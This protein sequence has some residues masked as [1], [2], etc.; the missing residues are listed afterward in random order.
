MFLCGGFNKVPSS[1]STETWVISA[2]GATKTSQGT[3]SVARGG[4]RLVTLQDG[5]ILIIGGST[6]GYD[7]ASASC[8]LYDPSDGTV[9]PVGSMAT[10]R[11]GHGVWLLSNGDVLVAGGSAPYFT[12]CLASA[13]IYNHVS[14]TWSATGSLNQ[15][16]SDFFYAVG[17]NGNPVAIAGSLNTNGGFTNT[18]EQYSSGTW[19]LKTSVVPSG[20]GVSQEDNLAIRLENGDIFWSGGLVA[21]LAS[22]GGTGTKHS[23]TYTASTDTLTARADQNISRVMPFTFR[24]YDGKILL[25]G[26]FDG[27]DTGTVYSSSELYDPE[28]DTW[29][30]VGSLSLETCGGYYDPVLITSPDANPLTVGGLTTG[31]FTNSDVMELFTQGSVPV[32]TG[33]TLVQ[34]ILSRSYPVSSQPVTVAATG[35]G[36]LIVVLV[37]GYQGANHGVNTTWTVV[38]NSGT[39]TYTAAPNTFNYN[40]GGAG[41]GWSCEIFY[42]ANAASCTEVTASPTNGGSTNGIACAV[43][44]YSGVKTVAPLD[45]SNNAESGAFT[46]SQTGPTL[47]TTEAGDVLVAVSVTPNNLTAVSAPWGNFISQDGVCGMADYKP[48]TSGAISGAVFTGGTAMQGVVSEAAFLPAP[49]GTSILGTTTALVF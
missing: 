42:C 23:Y 45:A 10:G 12:D 48:G 9:T 22:G 8:E 31:S 25:A 14:K 41:D 36:N 19:S 47:T 1:T 4:M 17:D 30:V 32:P 3:L 16:R 5:K 28:S 29:T 43:Y 6:N 18:I 35:V 38:D 44:E 24:R 2:D 40:R 11:Y 15:K 7:N 27:S 39:N 26:G 13:E 33:I 37:S 49:S 20:G 21:G 34:N 46:T